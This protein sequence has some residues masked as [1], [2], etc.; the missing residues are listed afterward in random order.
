MVEASGARP[1]GTITFLFTDIEGSTRLWERAAGAMGEALERHDAL[2]KDASLRYGGSIFST[3][4]D[5]F[6]IAFSRSADALAAAVEAQQAL[7]RRSWPEGVDLR[8]RM[9]LH[10]GEALERGGDYFGPAVNAAARLMAAGHG[11]Q[12]LC[13]GTVVELAPD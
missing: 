8:V 13:S 11:G 4:G 12:I 6:G 2:L 5:G 7:V 1:S 3:G 9:G 10:A